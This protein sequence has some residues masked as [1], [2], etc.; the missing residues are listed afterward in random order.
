MSSFSALMPPKNV[1]FLLNAKAN[2]SVPAHPASH[3]L[4]S[5]A[6]VPH[7]QAI[8]AVPRFE[9][10]IRSCKFPHKSVFH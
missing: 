7:G 6:F 3:R 1:H 9:R 4:G 10:K 2:K 5:A 8:Y